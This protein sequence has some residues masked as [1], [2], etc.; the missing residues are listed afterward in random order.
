MEAAERVPLEEPTA[1]E[2][3]NGWTAES[4]HAY[5]V[6]QAAAQAV[7]IDPKS[8]LRRRPQVKANKGSYRPL[9]WRG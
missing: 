3:R 8:L 9:R 1:D 2:L 7:K 5:R 6:D 4:L